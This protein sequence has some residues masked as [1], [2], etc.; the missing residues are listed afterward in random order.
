MRAKYLIAVDAVACAAIMTMCVAIPALG[1][2]ALLHKD[3]TVLRSWGRI[4]IAD[5]APF[6]VG[7]VW[8][9]LRAVKRLADQGTN[10]GNWLQ[11]FLSRA[12]LLLPLVLPAVI[13]VSVSFLGIVI[14]L[15]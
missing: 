14:K 13:C 10:P 7:Y 11:K 2:G 12:W 3:E 8:L 4:A 15:G 9:A 6:M 1:I 5:A